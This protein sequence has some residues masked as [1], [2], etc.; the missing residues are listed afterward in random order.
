MS[1][2]LTTDHYRKGQLAAKAAAGFRLYSLGGD[3]SGG[4]SAIRDERE[5]T[6][7]ILSL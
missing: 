7:D 6:A 2:E 5:I 1:L 4:G 3:S